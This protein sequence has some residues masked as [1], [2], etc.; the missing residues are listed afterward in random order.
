VHGFQGKSLKNNVLLKKREVS[1]L[2]WKKEQGEIGET[3]Y[4]VIRFGK[5]VR[6][7]EREKKKG[8]YLLEFQEVGTRERRRFGQV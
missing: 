8:D 6:T 7:W 1:G 2:T 3:P 5:M 4:R